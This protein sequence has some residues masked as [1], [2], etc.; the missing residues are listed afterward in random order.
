M[1]QRSVAHLCVAARP[2]HALVARRRA[3]TGPRFRERSERLLSD[4]H[5][6]ADD[7][8]ATPAAACRLGVALSHEGIRAAG[9]AQSP[10]ARF[11]LSA[12]RDHRFLVMKWPFDRRQATGVQRLN[13]QAAYALWA[14]S[15]PPRAHN[16]LM[17]VE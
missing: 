11:P 9:G 7:P 1:A 4:G 13:P 16:A 12:S 6:H 3:A 14:P 17:E 10:A 2:E 8:G 15:Y 5:R